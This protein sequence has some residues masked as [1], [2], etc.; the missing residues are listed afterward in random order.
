MLTVRL[1]AAEVAVEGAAAEPDVRVDDDVGGDELA[2][3]LAPEARRPR[4]RGADLEHPQSPPLAD[5]AAEQKL[6]R[7]GVAQP[8]EVVPAELPVHERQDGVDLVVRLVPALGAGLLDPALRLTELLGRARQV[9]VQHQRDPLRRAREVAPAAGAG[10]PVS[11]LAEPRSAEGT[12]KKFDRARFLARLRSDDP[13]RSFG[14][15]LLDQRNV[16]GIGNM[17][18]AECLWAAQV[19]PWA[20]LDTLGDDQLRAVLDEAH[21]LMRT[22][23]EGARPLRRVY[24]RTGRPCSERCANSIPACRSA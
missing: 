3:P 8:A 13:T 5:V 1:H 19:S 9:R 7:V 24:R 4:L 16:A 2:V 21:R 12:A 18:K 23:L 20:R 14:D 17:W 22:G 10:E 15:A 11:A 6:E